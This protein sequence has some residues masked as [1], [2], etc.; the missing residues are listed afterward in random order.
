[1]TTLVNIAILIVVVVAVYAIVRWFLSKTGT[2]IPQ[3]VLIAIY[4]IVAII[5]I[6]FVAGLLTGG[7]VAVRL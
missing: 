7:P 5:A 1:M 4:A 2:V 3:P 6:I